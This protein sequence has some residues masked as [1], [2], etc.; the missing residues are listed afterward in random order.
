M[1]TT[2]RARSAFT[3]ILLSIATG[4]LRAQSS[5]S[6]ENPKPADP[7]DRRIAELESR[8]ADLERQTIIL[9][10]AIDTLKS[11][12]QSSD[13]PDTAALVLASSVRSL[14]MD[15]VSSSSSAAGVSPSMAAADGSGDFA[16][17][18]PLAG[19]T[20]I[21]ILDVY[22][23][24]N[25][26]QPI[27]GL[28]TLRL[29]DDQTNQLA[30]GMLELGMTRRPIPASRFGFTLTGGFGDAINAVNS[31]D[32]GGLTFAQYL[33]EGYASYLIPAGHGLPTDVG[34]FDLAIGAESM[35][36]ANNWNYSRSF[37]YNYAI[38]FY[39][40]GVRSQYD[41]NGKY[42]VTGYLVNGW[43]N[44]V[45]T[46]SSGK[47]K[48]FQLAWRP[49]NRF[50]MTDA[51]LTGR[52][53]TDDT[54]E[55]TVNDAVARFEVSPKLSLMADG[56]YGRS[57]HE[58][59]TEQH[60]F[61]AGAAGYLQYRF[62]P[63]W[64]A[65]GR[66]EFYDDHSGITTCASSCLTPVPQDLK[67]ATATAERDVQ[68]HLQARLEGRYDMSNQPVFFRA[69]TPVKDQVTVTLGLVYMLQPIQQQHSQQ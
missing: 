26:H 31:S 37:L 50:S 65:A 64:V 51:W 27:S 30:L 13:P 14:T 45:D 23:S 24:Y 33:H 59:G 34:K 2:L 48:G 58:S 67:E 25:A 60:F 44:L 11:E 42:A 53:A 57:E 52:G 62:D 12:S 66:L 18:N 47:T 22:Y 15:P 10:Q 63:R 17:R 6:S 1:T 5:T 4:S 9:H 3:L 61:W 19:A 16:W 32:P 7:T 69:A 28:S 20:P 43:N 40:F 41:F 54:Q 29:F 56:V 21:G 68:R 46:Y 35:E 39:G 8:L 49:A 55:K 38:P 36:S